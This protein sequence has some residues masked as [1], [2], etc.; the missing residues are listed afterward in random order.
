[1]GGGKEVRVGD[2]KVE[3][4]AEE[5]EEDV[6]P[7]VARCWY[8]TSLFK[9]STFFCLF[10]MCSGVL[11]FGDFFRPFVFFIILLDLVEVVC[12]DEDVDEELEA[13]SG[14]TSNVHQARQSV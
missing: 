8:R 11:S 9:L 6:A 1:M 4:V 12:F 13:V 3:A 2:A 5:E 14:W 7:C 10:C